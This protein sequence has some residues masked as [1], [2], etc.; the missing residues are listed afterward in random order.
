[1]FFKNRIGKKDNKANPTLAQ[2]MSGRQVVS[3]VYFYSSQIKLVHVL[4][5][6]PKLSTVSSGLGVTELVN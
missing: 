3:N 2:D 4:N 1:M 6:V 5:M